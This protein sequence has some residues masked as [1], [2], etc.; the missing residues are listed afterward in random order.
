[1]WKYC[2]RKSTRAMGTHSQR[3]EFSLGDGRRLPYG[4][5]SQARGGE[6]VELQAEGSACGGPGLSENLSCLRK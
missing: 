2:N 3:T 1:M 4:E 6:I 5:G